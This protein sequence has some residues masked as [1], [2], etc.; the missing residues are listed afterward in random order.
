MSRDCVRTG[1]PLAA[2]ECPE[3][4]TRDFSWFWEELE[5]AHAEFETMPNWC[6]PVVTDENVLVSGQRHENSS[7]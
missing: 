6:R 7:D 2:C 1:L 4:C 3:G 5:R